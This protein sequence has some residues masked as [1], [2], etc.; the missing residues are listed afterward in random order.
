MGA[1]ITP[2]EID[3]KGI[4]D[5]TRDQIEEAAARGNV[6]KLICYGGIEAGKVIGR[7]RPEEISKSDLLASITGTSSIVTITTDL[8]GTISVVEEDPGIEQTGYGVFSDL[9]RLICKTHCE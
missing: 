6:I 4:E 3:R 2:K 5:I 1:G 9:L 8:M 7:V